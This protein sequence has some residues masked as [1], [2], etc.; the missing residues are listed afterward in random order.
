MFIYVCMAAH[1]EDHYCECI[2]SQKHIT[3]TMLIK[4]HLCSLLFP[5]VLVEWASTDC[6]ETNTR[7]TPTTITKGLNITK[8]GCESGCGNLIVPYPF[9]I[10]INSECSIQPSFSI[11]CDTSFNPPK[12]FIA[13][14]NLEIIDITD[15]HIRI[16]NQVAVRCYNELGESTKEEKIE[17]QFPQYF[18][19]SDANK[20]TTIGCDDLAVIAGTGRINFSSGCASTCYAE[21]DVL[22]GYCTGTGCCQTSIPNGL[23]GFTASLGSINKH[24]SLWSSDPCGYAFL[25]EHDSFTFHSS[26]LNNETFMNRTIQN[27]PILLDWVI[28]N[29][30]CSEAKQSYDF[31]CQNNSDCVDSNTNL[32]GYRC[33]CID[34]YEGNPYLEPGCKG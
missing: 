8:P 5:F 9:G 34:G 25:A 17:I 3:K 12:P 11:K 32:G 7:R 15:S 33:S 19:L 1:C 20:F 16:K 2:L 22:D 29:T 26:D 18:S 31:A 14:G 4:I 6:N 27:V 10:G 21:N 30:T 28:G 13:K 23:T 24:T